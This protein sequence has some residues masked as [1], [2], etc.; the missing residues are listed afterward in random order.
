[1]IRHSDSRLFSRRTLLQSLGVAGVTGLSG[2]IG[3]DSDL[4]SESTEP[5]GEQ[6]PKQTEE[7]EV[8]HIDLGQMAR[9]WGAVFPS[10]SLANGFSPSQM[11]NIN[12]AGTTWSAQISAGIYY[13]NFDFDASGTPET[14]IQYPYGGEGMMTK[15]DQLPW[16]TTRAKIEDSLEN[17]GFE[18][19]QDDGQFS[20][21]A[22]AQKS[23]AKAVSKEYYVT[24]FTPNP[25]IENQMSEHLERLETVVSYYQSDEMQIN[26]HAQDV[27]DRLSVSDY[28][29]IATPKPEHNNLV[30]T[31]Q[32]EKQPLAGVITGNISENIKEGVWKFPNES[33][34]QRAYT[35]LTAGDREFN[36]ID[37]DGKYITASGDFWAFKSHI[38][39]PI[40]EPTIVSV[41]DSK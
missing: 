25:N 4:D 34:A 21:Y 1:M 6:T 23:R 40:L 12:V 20:I 16:R 33:F 36:S 17:N 39:P 18:K 11:N 2:C 9:D 29:A 13:P 27:L 15:V 22:N 8:E 5:E 14:F 3:G 7:P 32:T 35:I 41:Y 37:R 10:G 26:D 28:L 31:L 30:A 19:L 38:H 24:S